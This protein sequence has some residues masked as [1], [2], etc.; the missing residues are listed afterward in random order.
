M[1]LPV[2][3]AQ[4]RAIRPSAVI[5]DYTPYI[6]SADVIVQ[7]INTK[8]SKSFSDAELEQIE[9]WLS[10]HVASVFDA[11][12]VEEKFENAAT[13]FDR[14]VSTNSSGVLST[15]YGSMANMLADGCLVAFDQEQSSVTFA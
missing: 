4:V 2:S 13:K 3:D 11:N 1:A 15:K 10:A 8:C 7:Q 12:I 9:I 14:A 5:A 6:A